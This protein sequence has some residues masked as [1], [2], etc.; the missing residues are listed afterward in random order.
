MFVISHGNDYGANQYG[1]YG[2][3]SDLDTS[4]D[5]FV[6]GSTGI[7][8]QGGA[9]EVRV[10]NDRFEYLNV[11]VEI[12]NYGGVKLANNDF[13]QNACTGLLL[14]NSSNQVQVVGGTFQNNG[15]NR[16]SGCEADIT[17]NRSTTAPLELNVTGTLFSGY[18]NNQPTYALEALGAANTYDYISFEN[19]DDRI[20]TYPANNRLP[21]LPAE[22]PHTVRLKDFY[23]QANLDTVSTSLSINSAGGVGIHTSTPSASAD[24][25]ASQGVLGILLP[26]GTTTQRPSCVTG[27][28]GE[29]RYNTTV[30]QFEI[31]NGSTW[32]AVGAG[33]A[34][35]GTVTSVSVTSANGVSG[36][37][38]TA[39]TTPAISLTL[40]AITPSS[41]ASTGAVSGTTV[42][43]S[44]NMVDGGT[45]STVGA[46][47]DGGALT[48]VG[49]V[50][51][52]TATAASSGTPVVNSPDL[53]LNGAWNSSGT[54]A[55]GYAKFTYTP[56][57][58]SYATGMLLLNM[59]GDLPG[60]HEFRA[61]GAN[62]YVSA[63]NSNDGLSSSFGET[64]D[65]AQF[66]LQNITGSASG[67]VP[68]NSFWSFLVMD[69][70]G[71]VYT[72]QG[73]FSSPTA[74]N[75]LD[76]GTSQK[77]MKLGGPLISVGT[78][79]TTSGCSV[80]ATAGGAVAGTYTSG[81]TG[82][83]TVVVTLGGA[84]G[85]TALTVGLV[86][87]MTKQPLPMSY[88]KPRIPQR[89][90]LFPALLL[91]GM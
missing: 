29:L 8:L 15:N 20:A 31:C 70:N 27:L 76:D 74:R 17:I 28:T 30:P 34:G 73:S 77:Q 36:T 13:D 11:G 72:N 66:G 90:R 82:T 59:N 62:T 89:L 65:S 71:K 67:V 35:T 49:N 63:L 6:S 42:T 23:L 81:T 41:V 37:V 61:S 45:L 46:I 5:T 51:A 57:S 19:I 87:P 38:A 64:F 26:N 52:S 22:T 50:T 39:T 21:I 12:Q 58:P 68:A 84:T 2:N 25:D 78:K 33:G 79:F 55:A 40:G 54:S 4:D 18:N 75:T 56:V 16:T 32:A 48:T 9:G 14:D 44:S 24:V 10:T 3:L 1:M 91:Q 83:C 85:V 7:V 47:T 80:S 69:N 88:I 60:A 86:L 43:S 53:T